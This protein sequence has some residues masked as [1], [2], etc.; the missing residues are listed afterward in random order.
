VSALDRA[1]NPAAR[2]AL[3]L[4]ECYAV[5]VPGDGV[6]ERRCCD[7]KGK[8]LLVG[9]AG[10]EA[11]DQTSRKGVAGAHRVGDVSQVIARSNQE[12]AAVAQTGRP[13]VGN[14][15]YQDVVPW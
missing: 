9:G 3:Y 11:V 15:R 2:E 4:V 7:R 5:E 10:D 12:L 8:R 13:L 6:L 1:A 14:V